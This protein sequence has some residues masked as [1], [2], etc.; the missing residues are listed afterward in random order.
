MA[1]LLALATLLTLTTAKAIPPHTTTAT[2]SSCLYTSTATNGSQIH[3]TN[4]ISYDFTTLS[5]LPSCFTV[6]DGLEYD[7]I[8][9]YCPRIFKASN[10][11][12]TSSGLKL[13]VPGGQ[14]CDGVTAIESAQVVSNISD[15]WYAS[16][17]TVASVSSVPGTVNGTFPLYP[18]YPH[19]LP[20]L[21]TRTRNHTVLSKRRRGPWH[22][23]RA[24]PRH[25]GRHPR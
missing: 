12:L 23:R 3:W 24:A 22:S 2:A 10:V 18:T 1:T 11:N 16:V 25:R 5:T 6:Q 13:T 20:I 14:V 19:P 7:S 4:H 9:P 15:I 17:R 8:A 21:P